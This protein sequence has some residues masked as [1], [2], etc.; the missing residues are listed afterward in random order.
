MHTVP[1]TVFTKTYGLK[2]NLAG[3]PV[4]PQTITRNFIRNHDF[5]S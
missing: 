1:P 3:L 2:A 4:S 5:G